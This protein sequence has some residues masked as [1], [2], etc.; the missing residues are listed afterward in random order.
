MCSLPWR[1]EEPRGSKRKKKGGE[2]SELH[3]RQASSPSKKK[4]LD[5]ISILSSPLSLP[6][7]GGDSH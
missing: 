1:K 7:E 6:S 2:K 4:K 3:W 5:H